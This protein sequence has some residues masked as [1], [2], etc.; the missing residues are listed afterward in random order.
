MQIPWPRNVCFARCVFFILCSILGGC[1]SEADS[2]KTIVDSNQAAANAIDNAALAVTLTH[3]KRQLMPRTITASGVIA[4]IEDMQLGVELNGLRINQVMVEVGQAVQKGQVLLSIDG[5]TVRSQLQQANALFE[6][7]KAGVTLADSNLNRGKELQKRKLISAADFDLLQAARVQA[8]ARLTTTSAQRDSAQLQVEFATLRAPD[9]GVI[10]KRIAQPGMVVMAGAEL[11]RLIRGNKLEWRAELSET[12][13]LKVKKGM[14]VKLRDPIAGD[15]VGVL[16]A[17][18][19]G[20]DSTT[21]TGTVMFNLPN[22]KNLRIGMFA[23]GFINVGSSEVLVLPQAAVVRRDGFAY[24]FVLP[25]KN[26]KVA[27]KR[28][29]LGD[30]TDDWIEVRDGL[31]EI[32]QV[33]VQGAGF[34]SDG[35]KVRAV[36]GK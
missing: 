4:P 32:D 31:G 33:I 6:E 24:A 10:S 35:D 12:D 15:V 18:S 22:P 9:D 5:R 2:N 1:K 16:R 23:Q 3:P 29:E 19:P 21:R 17:A 25:A 20:L 36:A 11:L 34:L 26:S 8:G 13:L 14:Q 7:A 27:R 30:Q 28:I